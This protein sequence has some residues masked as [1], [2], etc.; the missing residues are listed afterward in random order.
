MLRKT[1]LCAV[2][3]LFSVL[4]VYA[5]DVLPDTY[6]PDSRTKRVV[7]QIGSWVSRTLTLSDEDWFVI[8]PSSQGLLTAETAGDTDTIM[9]LYDGVSRV[10]EN[11][12]YG[13]GSNSRIEYPVEP[14]VAYTVMVRGYDKDVSGSYRFRA[15]LEPIPEDRAEPNDTRVQATSLTLGVSVTGYFLSPRDTDWYCLTIPAEG[16][17]FSV[18]TRGA[19]DTILELYD[20]RENL[21]A[22]DDD[23]GDNENAWLDAVVQAGTVYIKASAY[24]GQIGR[25]TLHTELRETPPMDRFEDDNSI[26]ASKDIQIGASQD[27]NFT[28]ASDEDWV[29]LRITRQSTYEIRAQAEDGI[30]DTYL[31]LYD[32][33]EELIAKDD[34]SGDNYDACITT[35]LSPGVYY[36]LVTTIDSGHLDNN[37]Y[38]LSVTSK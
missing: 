7:V 28:T 19:I 23:S 35:P 12:D 4:C 37:S 27:R 36:I 8:T 17:L 18:H 31:E 21:I 9:E 6:E 20:S 1:I 22:E 15:S 34:D 25:Y 2:A 38:T 29:R 3:A 16:G 13:S 11:D 30:L 5:Q 10:A 32:Q 14:G 26:A 33:N 24:E